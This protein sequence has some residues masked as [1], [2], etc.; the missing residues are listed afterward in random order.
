MCICHYHGARRPHTIK[1][2]AVHPQYRHGGE[3][4]DAKA[5]RSR[6]L[7]ALRDI[8]VV[9]FALRL[10]APGSTRWRGRKP[11]RAAKNQ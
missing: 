8:E 2:G 11:A 1:R 3:T 10:A 6:K 5:D 9:M 4:L 7:A